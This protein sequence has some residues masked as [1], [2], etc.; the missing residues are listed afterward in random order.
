MTSAKRRF[1]LTL[2]ILIVT[3]VVIVLLVVTRPEANMAM[4]QPGITRVEVTQV[5]QRDLLPT[6]EFTGVLR[7]R[8]IASLRFEVSG[9]LM[10]RQVEPGQSVDAGDLL[11]QLDDA[12]Y[13]DA[14]R[15]AE[16][17]LSE[18]RAA[19]ERDQA[20][21]KL[22][23]E[24]RRLAER[25]YQRLEKLGKGSLASV[26]TRESSR[27]QLINLQSEEARLGFGRQS[28]RARLARQEAALSR[29]RR[30]L[31]RTRLSAPFGGRVNRVMAEVGDYLQGNSLVLELIDTSALELEVAV[32]GDVAAAL[33]LGQTLV[34]DVDGRQVQGEL[35]ALQFDPDPQTHTHPLRIRIPGEG[36]LPGRLGRVG[37]P[38]RP[39]IDALV[40]PASAVMREEGKHYLF[41]V[42]EDRLVRQLVVPGIRQDDLQLIRRGVE[43][44]DLVVARDVEVLSHDIEVQV[45]SD[46]EAR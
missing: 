3:I 18:T 31:D 39:R 27:Q 8:Q 10:I 38:L 6:V 37:L 43:P 5:V 7:P 25:E 34:V 12:D 16:S 13:R 33:S 4:K 40:V 28:S 46:R 22:A 35:V 17:Q 2:A 26:S 11:L 9:E 14:L 21:L 44:G 41:L 23:G 20:L 36:L 32:S 24:N 45:E 42:R 29:A 19:L 30:N 1:F 15:E